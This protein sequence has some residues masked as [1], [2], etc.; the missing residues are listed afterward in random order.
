MPLPRC[1]DKDFIEMF[2]THGAA[3][4][5]KNLGMLERSVYR[6]RASLEKKIGGQ[7]DPP[8][9]GPVRT[10]HGVSHPRWVEKKVHDGVV[11]IGSDAHYWPDIVSTAHKAFVLFCKKFG[12]KL[13]VLNGDALDGT[14]ISRHATIGWEKSPSLIAE[15]K[16][17]QERLGEIEKVRGN[18][19]LLWPLGNHDGR[20]ETRLATVA[21][22]FAN[23]KGVH[24]KDHFPYWE[25]CWSVKINDD[26]VV[27]HRFK[28]GVHATHNNTL[29]SGKTTVTG[30][31]HQLKV[32]PL[33]DYNGRR[34]GVDSGTLADP[35]GPQF[36]SY[37]EQNPLNW[38]SGF[39]VLT[40]KG[41]MLL[42]PEL[43][44]VMDDGVVAFRGE[45][46]EVSPNG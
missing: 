33:S 24:L 9:D 35:Y 39:C 14:T 17:C 34:Y 2:Q 25:P 23:V 5:A 10:R 43:V 37:T 21:P 42:P 3:V 46:I 22:E 44:T 27:K 7:I 31:L 19:E 41:G 18:A 12:P 38:A 1:S 26:V 40:F 15:L 11:L 28:G 16:A 32:T 45:L 20:F 30:H 4:T 6:R 36:E 13:I 29:W 8:G